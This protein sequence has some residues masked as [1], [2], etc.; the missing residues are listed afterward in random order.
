M[1]SRGLPP[2]RRLFERFRSVPPSTT[3]IPGFLSSLQAYG[4]LQ[5]F[6]ARAHRPLQTLGRVGPLEARLAQT[7]AEVRQAQKL[8]YRVFY[9]EGPAIPNP[10]RLFARRDV[11]IVDTA[12]RVEKFKARQAK[13]TQNRKK[14]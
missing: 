4:G 5:A 9:Q 2:S 8:R 10:G 3:G 12:G 11:V 13:A 14:K 1:A 7:A 6:A